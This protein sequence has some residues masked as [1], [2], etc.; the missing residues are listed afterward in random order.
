MSWKQKMTLQKKQ[1]QELDKV[2]Q[3]NKTVMNQKNK[4]SALVCSNFNVNNITHEVFNELF[5]GTKYKHLQNVFNK[6]NQLRDNPGPKD[7]VQVF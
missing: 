5:A 1:Y 7:L 6:I 2:H 4:N 3:F